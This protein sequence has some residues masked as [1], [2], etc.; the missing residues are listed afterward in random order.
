MSAAASIHPSTG[1]QTLIGNVDDFAWQG[2]AGYL[3][4]T[5]RTAWGTANGVVLFDPAR[6]VPGVN[7]VTSLSTGRVTLLEGDGTELHRWQ[8]ERATWTRALIITGE[9]TLPCSLPE[10]LTEALPLYSTFPA[11]LVCELYPRQ[12]QYEDNPKA[13]KALSLGRIITHEEAG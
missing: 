9:T 1:A 7:L 4:A 12:D 11:R 8:A 2:G 6:S 10:A 3:A 13:L 5:L